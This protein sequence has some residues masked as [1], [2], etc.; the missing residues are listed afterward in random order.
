[1]KETLLLLE[2]AGRAPQSVTLVGVV[3]Q[4]VAM[5]TELTAPVRAAI[6]PAIRAIV[7]A[8]ARVGAPVKERPARSGVSAWPRG[9]FASAAACG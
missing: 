3:P 5:G 9:P 1:L 2:F 7:E 4:R 6:S 8:L